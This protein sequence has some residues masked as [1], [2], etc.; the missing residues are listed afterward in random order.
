MNKLTVATSSVKQF[1]S[2]HR[3]ALAVTATAV[4]CLAV[5]RVAQRSQIDYIKEKG[6]WEEFI[7]PED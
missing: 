4:A 5:N 6:L 1:V 2:N 7:T 3:V